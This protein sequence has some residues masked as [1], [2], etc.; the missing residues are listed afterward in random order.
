MKVRVPKY[1]D[2]SVAGTIVAYFVEEG[3]KVKKDEELL[4]ISTDKAL[5]KIESPVAGT[6]GTIYKVKGSVVQSND[7]LLDIEEI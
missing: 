6:I 1:G 2:N 4:E 3:S 5:F 7:E